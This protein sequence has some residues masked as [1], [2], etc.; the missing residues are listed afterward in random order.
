[1]GE[2]RGRGRR[3]GGT[4][5][6]WRPSVRTYDGWND[7]TS[8]TRDD[9]G[10]RARKGSSSSSSSYHVLATMASLAALL[11]TLL[12]S[13]LPSSSPTPPSLRLQTL[14]LFASL[15]RPSLPLLALF[16]SAYQST[17]ASLVQ[18]VFT[19][20]LEGDEELLGE[21][22]DVAIGSL[23]SDL[24]L[25]LSPD[26]VRMH[27]SLARS[28]EEVSSLYG[29]SVGVVRNLEGWWEMSECR[30]EVVDTLFVV[31]RCAFLDP[32]KAEEGDERDAFWEEME[33]VVSGCREDASASGS[34]GLAKGQGMWE[35]LERRFGVSGMIEELAGQSEI[36]RELAQTFRSF[37]SSTSSSPDDVSD[38]I[39][40]LSSCDTHL[41][42]VQLD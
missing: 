37:S 24:L 27:L 17:N 34:E 16:A 15:P 26:R 3:A 29:Q 4:R 22:E 6:S 36:A 42:I 14:T 19:S 35:D 31:L 9:G 18:K 25:V 13:Q 41:S 10:A 30:D 21:I 12:T 28:C 11:S 2:G 38:G 8:R 32:V 39:Y 40:T 23:E 5:R 20:A 1:M 33:D 7:T